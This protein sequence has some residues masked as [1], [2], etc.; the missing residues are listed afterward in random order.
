MRS[1]AIHRE[2]RVL[3]ARGWP[4]RDISEWLDVPRTTVR[5]IRVARRREGA[6]CPRCWRSAT[7]QVDWSPQRYAELLGFYLGDGYICDAG[8]TQRLRI[9]P[10]AKYP[11]GIARVHGP[12]R[13]WAI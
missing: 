9:S 4:D 3:A 10:D 12:R 2:V 11:Y 7:K 13:S 1:P 5:D 8:R 6:R